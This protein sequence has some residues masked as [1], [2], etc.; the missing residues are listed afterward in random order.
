MQLD[1]GDV[2][3]ASV[4]APVGVAVGAGDAMI[5]VAG[6]TAT[7]SRNTIE[8]APGPVLANRIVA[9]TPFATNENA[10]R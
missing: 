10:K 6:H 2:V 9:D 1:V 4:G 7:A 3:G 5:V 8:F